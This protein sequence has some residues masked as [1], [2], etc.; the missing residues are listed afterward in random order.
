M[1]TRIVMSVC[2]NEDKYIDNRYLLL[3]NEEP[4]ILATTYIMVLALVH[5]NRVDASMKVKKD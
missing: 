1:R 2:M 4:E 3:P 5:M